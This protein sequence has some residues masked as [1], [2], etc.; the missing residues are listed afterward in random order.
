MIDIHSHILPALD[1]GAKTLEEAVEMAQIAAADGIRQMV[2]TPHM[3]NGL[4]HNP[5]PG[6]VLERV[7]QLQEAVGDILEI[8][9]GN[10]VHV[11]HDIMSLAQSQ[12]VT[13]INRNN[14]MLVEFPQFSVPLGV[15][16]IFYQLCLQGTYPILVHPER[17]AQIQAR[18]SVLT[19]WIDRGL[20]VQ[21]TAMSLTGEFGPAAKTCAEK[22]LRHN[23]VHFIA[24]DT[25]RVSRRPPI[26]SKGVAAAAAIVGAK[27]AQTLVE[28][29]PE[30]VLRGEPISPEAPIPFGGTRSKR[31]FFSKLFGK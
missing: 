24:T 3:F 6:E 14:Y 13:T 2:A 21:V 19:P 5:E 9:P 7:A 18:P 28:D 8:L 15:D 16:D 30:A 17:N 31:T 25:H 23:C 27:K 29:H 26:L 4:S 1:D 22:L 10:E 11:T 12:R 20:L